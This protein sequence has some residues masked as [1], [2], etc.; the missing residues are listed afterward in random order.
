M[1][2][3][4]FQVANKVFATLGPSENWAMVKLRPDEQSSF[5]KLE[6]ASFEP[7]AGAWGRCGYTR[8]ELD[9]VSVSSAKEP[10]R[11]AWRN[12]APKR[13]IAEHE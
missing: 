11:A 3:A 12:T 5:M 7:L 9:S 13:L 2:A 8:I 10:L 1:N 6:P 4:D